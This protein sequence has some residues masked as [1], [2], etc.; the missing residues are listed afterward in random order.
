MNRGQFLKGPIPMAWLRA[1]MALGGSALAVAVQVRFIS[2]LKRA[3]TIR[4]RLASIP[5]SRGAAARGLTKL[6]QAEL[7]RVRRTTGHWPTV[8]ILEVEDD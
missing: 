3:S 4:L 1:A 7:V 2:G 5:V 8:R 6:E